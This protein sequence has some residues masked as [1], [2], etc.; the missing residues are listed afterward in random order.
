M[1][2]RTLALTTL[3]LLT[4]ASGAGASGVR[5]SVTPH[6][7]ASTSTFTVSYVA[8]TRTGVVGS[9]RIR[10]QVRAQTGSVSGGCQSLK[11]QAVPAVQ[12]GQHVHV[13]LRAGTGWCSGTYTGRLVE[14]VSLVCPRGALCP[15]YLRI[16]TLGTFTF[17]VD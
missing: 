6:A 8:P 17:V 15:Q 1:R 3:L 2:L 10:D 13:A 11:T 4:C 12:R 7:G 5:V 14:L 16:R 9:T